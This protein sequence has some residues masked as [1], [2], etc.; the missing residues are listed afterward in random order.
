MPILK[1]VIPKIQGDKDLLHD[2]VMARAQC[3]MATD[4]RDVVAESLITLRREFPGDAKVLYITTRYLSELANRTAQ[5]LLQKAP[6]SPEA[7]TLI[8]EA[9]QAQGKWDDA[10]AQYRKILEQ[11]PNQLGIHYQLGRI[12]L[13]KPLD[14]TVTEEATK[15]FEA[16]LKINPTSPSAEFMLGDLAWRNQKTEEAI[17]H[18]SR[19]TQFDT[20]LGEAYLGLGMALNAAGKYSEAIAPL[21]KYTEMDPTD[22]AG[23]YQ[24]ATAY[25]RTGNKP[26]A[27][28]LL[29][30]QRQMEKDKPRIV[31]PPPQDISQPH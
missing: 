2:A 11:N 24:L 4:Q 23:Y 22:P 8:A 16:E 15:E 29:A 5:E 21:K 3:G 28:R 6:S 19:A 18:F 13:S 7:E 12:L 14:P 10:T 30:L 26:E 1:R 27:D 17:E 25:A 20:G 31:T 9:F